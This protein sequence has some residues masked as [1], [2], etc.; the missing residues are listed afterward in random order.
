MPLH[1]PPQLTSGPRVPVFFLRCACHC[2]PIERLACRQLVIWKGEGRWGRVHRLT[3]LQIVLIHAPVCAPRLNRH[4][5]VCPFT[6]K[7]TLTPSLNCAQPNMAESAPQYPQTAQYPYNNGGYPAP[8]YAPAT[9]V[10]PPPPPPSPYHTV[11]NPGGWAHT[12][13]LIGQLGKKKSPLCEITIIEV[14][15]FSQCLISLS[16]SNDKPF[17]R[18][19]RVRL[20]VLFDFG[21][22]LTT[23]PL[24]M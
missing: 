4:P 19:R 9:A 18:V 17:C 16:L 12:G 5:T 10:Y 2:E 8:T 21:P 20:R 1:P 24:F 15:A 23:T 11:P 3:A 14:I 6:N 13:E 22:S 7:H